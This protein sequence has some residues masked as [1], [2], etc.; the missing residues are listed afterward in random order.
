MV[1]PTRPLILFLFASLLLGADDWY[2][3]Y[4]IRTDRFIPVYEHLYLSK[5]MV[6]FRGHTRKLCTFT[7]ETK[8]FRNFVQTHSQ[9]LLECLFHAGVLIRGT[10][11]TDRLAIERDTTTLILPPIPLKVEIND[12]LVTIY[13]VRSEK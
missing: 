9:A 7:A 3:S 12:G 8:R 11:R 13:E 2:L 1:S 5:A 6:P 10:S 4:R